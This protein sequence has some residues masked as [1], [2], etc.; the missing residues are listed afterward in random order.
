MFLILGHIGMQNSF[1]PYSISFG[2][3]F[4]IYVRCMQWKGWEAIITCASLL[5]E[6][7]VYEGA[8]ADVLLWSN[9]GLN[10]VTEGLTQCFEEDCSTV[11]IEMQIYQEQC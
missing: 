3:Q 8:W 5:G 7:E 4:C 11:C 1:S 2:L 10:D 6:K 9:A